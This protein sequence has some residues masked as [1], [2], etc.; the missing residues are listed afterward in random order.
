M[1]IINNI[2][3][4]CVLMNLHLIK[5]VILGWAESVRYLYAEI[6]FAIKELT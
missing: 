2:K 1:D 3:T 4:V 5:K 6:Y